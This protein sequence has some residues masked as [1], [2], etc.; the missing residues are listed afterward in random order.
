VEESEKRELKVRKDGGG[1]VE[2]ATHGFSYTSMGYVSKS[3][4]V[5]GYESDRLAK[6]VY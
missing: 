5:K 3:L 2:V 1:I 4:V 6:E